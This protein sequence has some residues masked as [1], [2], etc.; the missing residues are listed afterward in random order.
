MGRYILL[1]LGVS[2]YIYIWIERKREQPLHTH[3]W[4]WMLA[5]LDRRASWLTQ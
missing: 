1:L 4:E 3:G 5:G 2:A